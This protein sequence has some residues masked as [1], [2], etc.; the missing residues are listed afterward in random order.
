[1]CWPQ[2]A[3]IN[4]VDKPCWR[5]VCQHIGDGKYRYLH[6]DLAHWA[7]ME[8]TNPTDMRNFGWDW[9]LW[10]GEVV[11]HS[12]EASYARY[13]DGKPRYWQDNELEHKFKLVGGAA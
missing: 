7:V 5:H 6:K 11:F 13:P 4:E 12:K 8:P 1:M 10:D 9:L 2:F 3:I